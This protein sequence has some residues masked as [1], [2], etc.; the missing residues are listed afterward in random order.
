MKA[1]ATAFWFKVE[2][3]AHRRRIVVALYTSYILTCVFAGSARS[4]SGMRLAIVLSVA[5]IAGLVMTRCWLALLSFTREYGFLGDA[6]TFT[7]RDERQTAVRH[8]AFVRAY[9]ILSLLTSLTFAYSQTATG[10]GLW[11]PGSHFTKPFLFG[12]ILLST[13]L[14]AAIIA[15][16][17]ADD[18]PDTVAQPSALRV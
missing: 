5:A 14:P 2:T 9:W 3:K 17:E 16:T 15:W 10:L 7:S 8:A 4:S 11:V 12:L 13:S 6:R 1:D 18:L